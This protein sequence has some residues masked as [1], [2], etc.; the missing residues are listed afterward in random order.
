MCF[1]SPM[2]PLPSRCLQQDGAESQKRCFLSLLIGIFFCIFNLPACSQIFWRYLWDTCINKL[3]E[4]TCWKFN[5]KSH[6]FL[7][8][9]VRACSLPGCAC[10]ER[11][12]YRGII[13]ERISAELRLL[14]QYEQFRFLLIWLTHFI[15]TWYM[16]GEQLFWLMGHITRLDKL[17]GPCIF[18]D[19]KL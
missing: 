12:M 1:L 8:M 19:V 16:K 4:K 15:C 3:V 6:C 11:E 2:M 18:I 14:I 13:K 7:H 10:V 9:C 17:Y 5:G